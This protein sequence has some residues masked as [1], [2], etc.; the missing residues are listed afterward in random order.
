MAF[1]CRSYIF[2]PYRS[3]EGHMK[4]LQH[5]GH[6]RHNSK[7]SRAHAK[8]LQDYKNDSKEKQGQSCKDEDRYTCQKKG[9]K[10]WL[11]RQQIMLYCKESR[12]TSQSAVAHPG[13][14]FCQDQKSPPNI[15]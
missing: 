4:R 13:Y 15:Y 2:T 3:V 11:E 7:D 12:Q 9:T 5:Q 1:D 14:L 8:G 6:K 10:V